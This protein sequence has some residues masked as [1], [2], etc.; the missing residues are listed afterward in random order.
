MVMMFGYI[1]KTGN[2]LHINRILAYEFLYPSLIIFILLLILDI[3][4][5]QFEIVQYGLI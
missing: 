2:I 1:T 3:E 4:H 5:A